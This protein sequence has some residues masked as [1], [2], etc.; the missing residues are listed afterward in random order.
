MK[1]VKKI[2]GVLVL[3]IVVVLVLPINVDALENHE[4]LIKKIAPDGE[5]AVFKIRKPNS[6]EE[7]DM[8]INGY[9]NNL[10]Q[11]DGYE[12]YAGCNEAPYTSC[13]V[14]IRTDDYKSTWENGKEV[15]LSG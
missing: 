10:L 3:T 4:D 1:S 13:T 12:I 8:L 6:I 2:L 14:S 15:V 9:V 5:N 11:E 7:G